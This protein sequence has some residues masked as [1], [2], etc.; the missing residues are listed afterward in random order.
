MHRKQVRA[1]VRAAA[2]GG[3]LV[4][5]LG[6]A[7]AAMAQPPVTVH[8]PCY[9]GALA[10]AIFGATSGETIV[11][12][13]GCVYRLDQALPDVKVDLTIIGYDT[14]LLRDYGAPGFSILTI[15]KGMLGGGV[16][17]VEH[18]LNLAVDLTV[19]NVDF[20]NGGG[21]DVEDGGAINAPDGTALTV[22]GGIFTDN[23]SEYGG[24]IESDD[25]LTVTGAYFI[26]NFAYYEGGGIY[27]DGYQASV[28]GSTFQKNATYDGDDDDYGGGGIYADND[29]M[30]VTG[31]TFTGNSSYEGGAVY[32]D[33]DLTMARD[34]ATG[35]TARWGGGVY[36]DGDLAVYGGLIYYNW[37][38]DE[39]GGIYNDDCG[40]LTLTHAVLYGNV[41]DNIFYEGGICVK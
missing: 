32:T 19:V 25:I 5:G 20:R 6:T 15:D 1:A 4:L 34:D 40:S 33:D 9:A 3:T 38:S 10:A 8:V 21:P 31:S 30:Q 37:A 29:D 39:G 22:Q 36:N 27:T 12:A 17:G 2:V 24:A 14:E 41:P 26:G 35:N 28:S 23:N 16:V 7:S 18:Q 11:L 13:P